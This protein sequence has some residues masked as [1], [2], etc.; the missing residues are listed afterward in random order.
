M[1]YR[2]DVFIKVHLEDEDKL[3][4]VLKK[5]SFTTEKEYE[6][7]ECVGYAIHDVKW[8]SDYEDVKAVNDF[9]GEESE[10]PRG[11]IAI[12]EDNAKEDYGEPWEVGLWVITQVAWN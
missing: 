6:D 3:V 1:G 4:E 11:L 8:Y 10:Y 12:G 2:S 5:N 7:K 9:V